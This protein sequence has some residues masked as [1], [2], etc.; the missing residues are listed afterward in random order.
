MGLLLD[1][2][3]SP[4]VDLEFIAPASGTVRSVVTA[5]DDRPPGSK[6]FMHARMLGKTHGAI[7][8][9]LGLVRRV[10]A[11]ARP[12]VLAALLSSVRMLAANEEICKEFSDDGGIHACLDVLR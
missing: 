7:K 10:S 5:D 12:D 1:K 9:L 2:L 3:K 6:A 11:A 8:V 4:D